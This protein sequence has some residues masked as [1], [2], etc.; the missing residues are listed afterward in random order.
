MDFENVFGWIIAIAMVAAGILT[1]G[2]AMGWLPP[3]WVG[4]T[5]E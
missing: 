4:I 2:V 3:E 1:I 5:Q